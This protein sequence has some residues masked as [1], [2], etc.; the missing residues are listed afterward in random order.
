MIVAFAARNTI[1]ET[2]T[3]LLVAHWRLPV[4][5]LVIVLFSGRL[6]VWQLFYVA[7]S[8]LIN[9]ILSELSCHVRNK[10]GGIP[11]GEGGQSHAVEFAVPEFVQTKHS[12]S[13]AT[14]LP[15][16]LPD[17]QEKLV[18]TFT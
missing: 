5:L 14:V 13:P 8:I 11:G 6:W 16:A 9:S 15:V 2:V 17:F 1:P 4:H 10:S 18:V 7:F 12:A 3:E